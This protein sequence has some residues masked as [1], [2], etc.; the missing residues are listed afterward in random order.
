[1]K[2][3]RLLE[4]VGQ[5]AVPQLGLELRLDLVAQMRHVLNGKSPD[6]QVVLESPVPVGG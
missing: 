1:V 2:R 6:V 5:L 3:L 4:L